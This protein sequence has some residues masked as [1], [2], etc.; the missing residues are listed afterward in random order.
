MKNVDDP[1]FF[2]AL[3]DRL[4]ATE[5]ADPARVFVT[6]ISNGGLM[7]H[8]LGCELADK[9]TAIAPVVRTLTVK[10]AGQCAPARPIPVLMFFGTADKLVPFEGGIQKMGSAETPVLSAHQTIA[11]WAELDGCSAS[12]KVGKEGTVERRS[13]AGCKGGTR[14]EAIIREGAGHTWPPGAAE[15]I[16]EFFEHSRR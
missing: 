5:N 9:I 14:V 15:V 7:S 4:I 1:G 8:R 6:G 12:P 13:Y 11:K 16:W 2:S 10:L 3:I